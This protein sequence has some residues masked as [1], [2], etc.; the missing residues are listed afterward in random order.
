MD[1]VTRYAEM[2]KELLAMVFGCTKFKDSV[3]GKATIVKA[4]DHQPLVTVMKKPI[5]VAPAWLQGMLLRLQSYDISLVYK[6]GKHM[7][8]AD[9]LF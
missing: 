6:K 2:E 7:Y 8:L 4:I 5:H 9:T 1:T 3:Y